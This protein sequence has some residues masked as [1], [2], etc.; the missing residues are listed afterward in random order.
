MWPKS[1][2]SGQPFH[3]EVMLELTPL[4]PNMQACTQC[5][6]SGENAATMRLFAVTNKPGRSSSLTLEHN[7]DHRGKASGSKGIQPV[8]RQS[9]DKRR[10][11]GNRE[12]RHREYPGTGTASEWRQGI[13]QEEYT[14]WCWRHILE[15]GSTWIHC[16]SRMRPVTGWHSTTRMRWKC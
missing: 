6:C 4:A 2:P 13:D 8:S 10:L 5:Q 12:S 3:V 15:E 14:T 9:L 7:A 11:R 1:S 16:R